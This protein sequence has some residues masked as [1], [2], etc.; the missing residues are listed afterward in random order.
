MNRHERR[1]QAKLTRVNL[2]DI[3]PGPLRHLTLPSMLISR[4]QRI[5]EVFKGIYPEHNTAI[6]WRGVKPDIVAQWIEGFQRDMH[7]ENEVIIWEGIARAFETYIEGKDLSLNVRKE[8]FAIALGRTMG[9]D[10]KPLKHLTPEQAADFEDMHAKAWAEVQ[11]E[12]NFVEKRAA[13]LI[14]QSP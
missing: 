4:I 8:L 2:K 5:A 13:A 10:S 9:A 6:H 14:D 1:K 11:A 3:K 12:T 7:P